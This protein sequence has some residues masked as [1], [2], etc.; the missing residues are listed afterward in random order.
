MEYN[1]FGVG[2]RKKVDSYIKIKKIIAKEKEYY[3]FKVERDELYDDDDWAE[4]RQSL[5]KYED[6]VILYNDY[7][8]MLIQYMLD[9]EGYLRLKQVALSQDLVTEITEQYLKDRNIPILN[10]KG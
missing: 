6:A 9:N 7:N 10:I 3:Y 1:Y 8:D 4:I 2:I 5:N